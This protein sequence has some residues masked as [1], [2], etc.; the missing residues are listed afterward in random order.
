MLKQN[1]A[2]QW[3]P[4]EVAMALVS[5]E[6]DLPDQAFIDYWL[7]LQKHVFQPSVDIGSSKLW[8]LNTEEIPLN[9]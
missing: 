3:V 7:K 5:P 6:S 9:R 2:G 1:V 8:L 4:A